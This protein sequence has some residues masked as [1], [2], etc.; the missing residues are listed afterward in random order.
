MLGDCWFFFW[1]CWQFRS[2]FGRMFWFILSII[3]IADINFFIL[4]CRCRFCTTRVIIFFI[5]FI[6]VARFVFLVARIAGVIFI[7]VHLSRL[8]G[9]ATLLL[10]I[11]VFAVRFFFMLTFFI[12]LVTIV[13]VAFCTF[14]HF[15]AHQSCG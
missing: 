3:P 4:R 10:L 5:I 13:F 2:F 9:I 1:C 6:I 14:S 12:L 8:F 15:L 11:F 7:V